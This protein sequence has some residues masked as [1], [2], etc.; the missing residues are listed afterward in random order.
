[1]NDSSALRH[2]A[3][4]ATAC[5]VL[6]A[7]A[8]PAY[9]ACGGDNPKIGPR[10]RAI[11]KE[12]NALLK[13]MMAAK[14]VGKEAERGKCAMALIRIGAPMPFA[15]APDEAAKDAHEAISCLALE[16]WQ[17]QQECK[18]SDYGLNFSQDES[19]EKATLQ[20]YKAIQALSAK[21]RQV[22]IPNKAIRSFVD[23]A[24]K[25]KSCFDMKT[26]LLLEQI[27]NDIRKIIDTTS[28]PA[29]PH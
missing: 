16:K 29:S 17:L 25:I 2:L 26:V 19:A 15:L 4:Y 23:R 21:A 3:T 6:F 8:F 28:V 7:L 24:E 27:E 5:T 18:C 13:G 12:R 11:E 1:M 10:I 22:G 9:A 14:L 20:S